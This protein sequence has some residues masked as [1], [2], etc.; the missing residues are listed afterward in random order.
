ME[1]KYFTSIVNW[2]KKTVVVL[3]LLLCCVQPIVAQIGTTKYAIKDGKMHI[4][5]PKEISVKSLD[6]FI[7]QYNL[8][9][10][11]LQQFV[12]THSIDSL[13]KIGWQLEK[14]T[15]EYLE[16]SKKM[17]WVVDNLSGASSFTIKSANDQVAPLQQTKQFGYNSFKHNQSFFVKGDTVTFILRR[18]RKANKVKL[19]G[20]FNNWN[21]QSLPMQLTDS[22]WVASVK[23]SVGKN[24]YKFI[25]DGK[26]FIDED[27]NFKEYDGNGNTNSVYYLPNYTFTSHYFST[28]KK[29]YIAGSFNDWNKQDLAMSFTNNTWTLPVYLQ[30]GIH[31]YRFIVDGKWYQDPENIDSLPNEFNSYNS[32]V[33][34]GKLYDITINGFENAKKVAIV[35]DFNNWRQDEL[36]LQKDKQGWKIQ[37]P[38]AAGNF[39]Y[40]IKVDDQWFINNETFTNEY[41]KATVFPYVINPNYVFRLDGFGS[42]KKIFVAGTFNNWNPNAFELNKKDTFWQIPMHV[43][44]GKHLYKFV[45][46]DKWIVDPDNALWEQ[47]E[48]QTKNSILWIE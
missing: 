3:L 38:L 19:A 29:I 46:D 41:N 43:G 44:K 13:S 37:L 7:V 42:A 33:R 10:L 6:S 4:R 1:V 9:D 2:N 39:Q 5:L 18:N 26:W 35:G 31:R 30:D 25:V 24:L 47:N 36:Y 12:K 23:L 11:D 8:V 40:K 20:T 17:D 45:V 22:G 21:E 27:N 28:A 32:V 34:L 15:S 16:I 14:N 48:F